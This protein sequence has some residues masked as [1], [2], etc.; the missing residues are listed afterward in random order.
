MAPIAGSL[1]ALVRPVSRT[2]D[3]LNACEILLLLANFGKEGKLETVIPRIS[4]ETLAAR[5]GT[6]RSRINSFMNKFQLK[7][8]TS[9]LNVIIHD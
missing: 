8:H 5:V 7:V 4:Q 2:D 1:R 6:T 3:G 9:L